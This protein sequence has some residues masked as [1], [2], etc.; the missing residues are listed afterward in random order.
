MM[1]RRIQPNPD[2][3]LTL[4]AGD[5]GKDSS[6]L[7]WVRP[8]TGHSG[9]VGESTGHVVTEHEDGTISVQPS[10]LD[11]SPGGYH[12]FLTHGVWSP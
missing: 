1:G 6:G 2:G 3:N 8:P 9:V 4:A 7:W 10:I 5:Y 12:G 11:D